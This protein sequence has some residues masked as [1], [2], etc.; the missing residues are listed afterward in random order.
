MGPPTQE[1]HGA[2]TAAWDLGQC[3]LVKNSRWTKLST[4][5]TSQVIKTVIIM[6]IFIRL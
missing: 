1:P 3:F 2:V 4:L 6:I 5:L